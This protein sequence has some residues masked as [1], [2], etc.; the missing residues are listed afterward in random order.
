MQPKLLTF[1]EN[2]L[3]RRKTLIGTINDQ[4]KDF[5]HIEHTI[6]GSLLNAFVPL[7]AR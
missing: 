4:F 5:W 3:L 1:I 6:Q 7:L 2:L